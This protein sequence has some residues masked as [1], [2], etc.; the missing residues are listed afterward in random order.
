[1]ARGACP[2]VSE[3]SRDRQAQECN[4]A[5]C[6]DLIAWHHCRCI[7]KRISSDAELLW[8]AL[9]SSNDSSGGKWMSSG[10][11]RDP[12]GVSRRKGP[13]VVGPEPPTPMGPRSAVP[14]RDA[15]G[16]APGNPR[17]PA[18]SW[19]ANRRS[20]GSPPVRLLQCTECSYTVRPPVGSAVNKGPSE[21]PRATFH[22]FISRRARPSRSIPPLNAQTQHRLHTA[23]RA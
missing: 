6:H 9:A 7:G 23:D 8:S 21:Q 13:G 12:I 1:M 17:V 15:S 22:G 18:T 11:T 16:Q 4:I 3:H 14:R 19:K 10:T 2:L 20:Q 5:P